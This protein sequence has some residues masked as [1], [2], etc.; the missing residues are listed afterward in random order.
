MKTITVTTL[1]GNLVSLPIDKILKIE[2]AGEGSCVIST[3]KGK[4]VEKTQCLTS[5]KSILEQIKVVEKKEA[6]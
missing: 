5:R 6:L 2:E 4:A 3:A 1:T